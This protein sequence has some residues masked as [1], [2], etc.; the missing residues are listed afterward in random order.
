MNNIDLILRNHF[1]FNDEKLDFYK[2]LNLKK[3]N[4]WGFTN[5]ELTFK[6]KIYYDIQS[7]GKFDTRLS[8]IVLNDDNFFYTIYLNASNN[9]YLNNFIYLHKNNF[10]EDISPNYELLYDKNGIIGFK[11]KKLNLIK[12]NNLDNIKKKTNL[13]DFYRNIILRLKLIF[14][15]ILLIPFLQGQS[16]EYIILTSPSLAEAADSLVQLYSNYMEEVCYDFAG[17]YN[18]FYGILISII[19]L[20]VSGYFIFATHYKYFSIYN[21]EIQLIQTEKNN[22]EDSSNDEV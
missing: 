1:S 10:Y 16:T 9:F 21:Y 2:K 7:Y 13:I 8:K 6:N 3:I 5:R 17:I 19:L 22:E 4:L 12:K 14:H 18:N 15:A 20:T 11:I